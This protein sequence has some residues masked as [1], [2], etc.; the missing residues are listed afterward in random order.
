MGDHCYWADMHMGHDD[1]CCNGYGGPP[2]PQ[3]DCSC[4][5]Y[6]M[7][8]GDHCWDDWNAIDEV[9][10]NEDPSCEDLRCGD[11]NARE[12]ICS[13]FTSGGWACDDSWGTK[14]IGDHPTGAEYNSVTLRQSGVCPEQCP[15][16]SGDD[17]YQHDDGDH[18]TRGCPSWSIGPG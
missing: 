9:C 12:D 6:G 11:P 3:C 8:M 5:D 4:Y 10:C 17:G 16:G 15:A 18:A 14:C 7:D 1:V 13:A 2:P